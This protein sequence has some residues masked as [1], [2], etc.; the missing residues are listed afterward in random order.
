[1]Q[2]W[3][4][5]EPESVKWEQTVTAHLSKRSI[6]KEPLHW[7]RL[8]AVFIQESTIVCLCQLRRD[9]SILHARPVWECT[10]TAA[11]LFAADRTARI[12][13]AIHFW[14][15]PAWFHCTWL[16]RSIM[17]LFLLVLVSLRN[18]FTLFLLNYTTASWIF[19]VSIAIRCVRRFPQC[20]KVFTCTCKSS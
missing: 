14:W 17:L 6:S 2:D 1:M 13:I 15:S 20:S 8:V 3:R 4:G 5:T 19:W 9:I 7:H 18:A 10:R 16:K 11:L 12:F